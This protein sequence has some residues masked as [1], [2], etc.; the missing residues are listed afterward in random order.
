MKKSD[1]LNKVKNNEEIELTELV[2]SNGFIKSG[3]DKYVD[4]SEIK[5]APQQTSDDL[6]QKARQPK[7]N[8]ISFR[9]RTSGM[10]RVPMVN[11]DT[12]IE[13]FISNDNVD[14]VDNDI[15]DNNPLTIKTANKLISVIKRERLST[16]EI[17]I[18]LDLIKG[19][20]V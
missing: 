11:E 9:G 1:F 13:D 6:E 20:L 3:S 2:D 5:V 12:I 8:Y 14:N 10:V 7:M 16:E 4:N 17:N 19:K 18:V 15:V